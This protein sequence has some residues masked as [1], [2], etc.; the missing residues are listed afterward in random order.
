MSSKMS[1]FPCTQ[2]E[3]V[4]NAGQGHQYQRSCRITDLTLVKCYHPNTHFCSS[5]L[6]S[7]SAHTQ[8]SIFN[9]YFFKSKPGKNYIRTVLP[10]TSGYIGVLFR[11]STITPT[12]STAEMHPPL[13]LQ[14]RFGFSVHVQGSHL[15]IPALLGPAQSS[16]F[17]LFFFLCTRW[18]QT[19]QQSNILHTSTLSSRE[20][21]PECK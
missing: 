4:S 2:P 20:C 16:P 1:D 7:N 21:T 18:Q 11:V 14:L 12:V 17:V 13:L 8:M 3:R 19:W 6:V 15:F 10:V 9:E 5:K